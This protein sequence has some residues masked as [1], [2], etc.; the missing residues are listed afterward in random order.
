M[1]VCNTMDSILTN[2][3]EVLELVTEMISLDLGC[4]RTS[5][6]HVSRFAYN[7][8]VVVMIHIKQLEMM[9]LYCVVRRRSLSCLEK[10]AKINVDWKMTTLC[11][12]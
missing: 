10:S 4:S 3:I 5:I 2:F 9:Y 1:T 7:T 8:A 6:R 12:L 11:P